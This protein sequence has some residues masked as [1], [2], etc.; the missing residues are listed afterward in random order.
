MEI[1]ILEGVSWRTRWLEHRTY[2]EKLTELGLFSL[3]MRI[4][5]ESNCFK[6]STGNVQRR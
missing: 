3:K 2:K 6:L 4:R 5:G 1:D